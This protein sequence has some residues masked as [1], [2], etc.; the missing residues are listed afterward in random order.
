MIEL[1]FQLLRFG[2]VGV[3]A[4]SIHFGTVIILVQKFLL[5][6]LVANVFGFLVS[7]QVSYWGHRLWTFRRTTIMHSATFPKLLLVQLLNLSLN[8]LL[9]Y[10]FLLMNL[11]YPLALLIVLTILPVFTFLSSKLW[12]FKA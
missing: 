4:A 9:F 5:L 6:P 11:P 1:F 12:V 2:L 8:E 10:V 3:S 7:F